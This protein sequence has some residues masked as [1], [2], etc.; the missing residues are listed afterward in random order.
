MDDE[1]NYTLDELLDEAKDDPVWEPDK[2]KR[3]ELVELFRQNLSR[4]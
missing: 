4:L 1:R 3:E 2:Q